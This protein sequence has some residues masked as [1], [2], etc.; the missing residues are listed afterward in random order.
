MPKLLNVFIFFMRANKNIKCMYVCVGDSGTNTDLNYLYLFYVKA[1]KCKCSSS[2]IER[3][4][5][6]M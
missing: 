6:M 4:C 5:K 2:P 1:V 3:D